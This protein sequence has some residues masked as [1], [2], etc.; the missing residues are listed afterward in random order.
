MDAPEHGRI[1]KLVNGAFTPRAMDGLHHSVRYH[2]Q[3]IVERALQAEQFDAVRDMA[4]DLPLLVLADM[5]GMPR[6]ERGLILKWSNH[7]VGF[8]D[9][10][11]GGGSIEV[12]QR[13]F[14][15]LF[16]YASQLARE[17]RRRPTSDL[18]GMLVNHAV[19]GGSLSE[20]EFCNL[21]I[22]LVIGGN[23]STRHLLSGMLLALAEWHEERSRLV[24][25]PNIIPLA[26]EEFLRWV[27]PVMQFRRTAIQDVELGG[28]KIREGEKVVLYYIS[29]NMDESVFEAPSQL[30]LARKPNPHLAF[31]VGPHFCLGAH[32]ARLEAACLLEAIRPHLHSFCIEDTPVRLRSNFMNGIKS[33]PA[34]FAH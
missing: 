16:D 14:V 3:A 23:E 4:A 24:S 7:L 30:N 21:W 26:V 32:L 2:A 8:D 11:Y 1:R 15:E 25:N 13:T 12:Y 5:L 9:P 27:S 10:E 31:G 17:K 6:E 29:G 18:I 28:Q 22:L 19:G 34:H 20:A 33:M